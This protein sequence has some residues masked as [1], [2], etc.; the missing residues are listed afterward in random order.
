[1]PLVQV[2][3]DSIKHGNNAKFAALDTCTAIKARFDLDGF[4]PLEP[5]IRGEY[6]RL[7][8]PAEAARKVY[9][10][11]AVNGLASGWDVLPL[12]GTPTSY[13][14]VQVSFPSSSPKPETIYDVVVRARLAAR[15]L[16]P[17]PRKAR[18]ESGKSLAR[19]G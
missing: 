15:R 18:K 8:A 1:M 3:S 19:V 13:N 12:D 6:V 10:L 14:I 5:S 9:A 7:R 16:G 4:K 11:R 2:T 17:A